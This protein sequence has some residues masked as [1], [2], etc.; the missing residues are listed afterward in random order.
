MLWGMQAG[1]GVI[2]AEPYMTAARLKDDL[3][4]FLC[5]FIVAEALTEACTAVIANPKGTVFL[6]RYNSK[7]CRQ[8]F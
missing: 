8:R 5:V 1:F 4:S 6:Y 2:W 7:A 3:L